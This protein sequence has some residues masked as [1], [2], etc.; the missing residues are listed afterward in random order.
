MIQVV[1]DTIQAAQG[2]SE[3]LG[4]NPSVGD[5]IQVTQR[6]IRA[7]SNTIQAV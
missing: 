7:A 3:Q 4:G 5:Q 6:A 2:K 1:K